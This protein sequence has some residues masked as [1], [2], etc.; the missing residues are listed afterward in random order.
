L[1]HASKG[2][3]KYL[4]AKRAG[5]DIGEVLQRILLMFKAGAAKTL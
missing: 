5:I 4:Q 3:K 2:V 1:N